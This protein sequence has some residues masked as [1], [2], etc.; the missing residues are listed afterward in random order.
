VSTLL[1]ALSFM[2][3]VII[4]VIV[5]TSDLPRLIA[6]GDIEGLQ[7]LARGNLWGMLL[8]T[9][10]IMLL[11]NLVTVVPLILLVTVNAALFDFAYGYIWSWIS[12]VVAGSIVFMLTRYWLQRWLMGKVNESIMQRI[13]RN[14]LLYVLGCRLIPIMPSSLINMA[15]GAS[16]IRYGQFLLG[17]LIGNFLFMSALAG[18]T[19]GIMKAGWE[20]AA[21]L[22]ILGGVIGVT[23][24][25]RRR[26]RTKKPRHG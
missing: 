4:I 18:V 5:F 13:E 21:L 23:I 17:S 9:F 19:L 15:A 7:Q 6:D 14:G 8:V 12:S 24:Y 16:S 2:I 11:Q 10:L 1:R 22:F 25:V 26:A 3:I 20:I